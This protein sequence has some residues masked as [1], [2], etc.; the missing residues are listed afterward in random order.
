MATFSENQV[1]HLYV[2]GQ[3]VT[4]DK[5]TKPNVSSGATAVGDIM[6]RKN[7]YTGLVYGEYLGANKEAI[8]T[9]VIDPKKILY[10]SYKKADDLARSLKA[11]K[12]VLDA[13]PVVGQDYYV[14]ILFK[15]FAS[16]GEEDTYV[17]W[18]SAHASTG[19][20]KSSI[21]KDL[22]VSLVRNFVPE[23]SDLIKVFLL[24]ADGKTEVT[25]VNQALT[26]TYTGLVIAEKEQPWRRGIMSSDPV[27]FTVTPSTITSNG[28][29]VEWGTVTDYTKDYAVKV[30]NGKNIADLEYFLM[31]ERGDQYRGIG[32]PNNWET[33]Y[34]VDPTKGYDVVSIHY[35]TDEANE[36][37]QKSEKDITFV[38]ATA[39]QTTA[40]ISA[41]NTAVGST[42]I[43]E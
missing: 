12:V 9:D 7:D 5:S 32:F 1:N 39:E 29:D 33:E 34:L 35:Y 23:A 4:Y 18:A 26:G 3:V 22:A 2:V 41:I 6:I 20:T 13:D 10:A 11:Q 37:V 28:E 30:V 14:R 38:C 16:L 21:Y 19:A 8:R 17:K 25:S 15:A 27:D 40:L 31:G 43:S 24:T 42:I 36:N